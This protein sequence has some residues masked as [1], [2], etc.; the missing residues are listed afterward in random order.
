MA[1]AGQGRKLTRGTADK[2]IRCFA[3]AYSNNPA[4]VP[5]RIALSRLAHQTAASQ[6]TIALS[7][8][9]SKHPTRAE[10]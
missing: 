1:C 9:A 10:L 4:E 3:I 7:I 8:A 6:H 5:P 2:L